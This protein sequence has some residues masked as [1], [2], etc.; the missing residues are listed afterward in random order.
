MARTIAALCL[1]WVAAVAGAQQALPPRALDLDKAK[2][3][4]KQAGDDKARAYRE[5]HQLYKNCAR[6]FRPFCL[7]SSQTMMRNADAR[8]RYREKQE[9]P[10]IAAL[11]AAIAAGG[12][13]P[14]ARRNC[15]SAGCAKA[16][17]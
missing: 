9:F 7:L 8:Y 13:A 2:A 5:A 4:R 15:G 10:N 6:E 3:A 1:L 16:G 17:E 14:V 12:A 11:E